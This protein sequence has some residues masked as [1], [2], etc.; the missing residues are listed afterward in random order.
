MSKSNKHKEKPA[1]AGFFVLENFFN[2]Y[3]KSIKGRLISLKR[4]KLFYGMKYAW[5]I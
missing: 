5:K 2:S 1:Q 3:A 4:F